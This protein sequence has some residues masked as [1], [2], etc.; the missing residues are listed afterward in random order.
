M[1]LKVNGMIKSALA[2]FAHIPNLVLLG[3]NAAQKIPIFSFVIKITQG[4]LL[5]PNFVTTL[6]SDMFGI[7]T[8]SK[9]NL[10]VTQR[11]NLFNVEIME[12]L[13]ALKDG[14]SMFKMCYT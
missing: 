2:G 5:H 12:Y 10:T 13:T 7:Q 9:C 8:T 14:I 3:N 6:L 11:F 4:K 1:R